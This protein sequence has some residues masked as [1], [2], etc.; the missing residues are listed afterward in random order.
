MQIKNHR[1]WLLSVAVMTS[2]AITAAHPG[3]A[4]AQ[5]PGNSAAADPLT[6]S[7]ALKRA[8]GASPELG[9]ARLER[10]AAQGAVM[11]G[12]ARPNP[13]A[14]Y[15]VE[16]TRQATRTTTLQLSQPIELGGKRAARIN[17]AE[18]GRDIAA[19]ELAAREA[20][21]RA[22]VTGH[23]FGVVA[24]QEGV[25]LAQDSVELARHASDAAAKRVQA[26]KV[27]PVEETRSRVA[28]ANARLELSKAQSELG[29]AR[30]R[31]AA[32][33]GDPEPRFSQAQGSVDDLP[34][35]ISLDALQARLASSPNLQRAQ[36]EIERR[37]ALVDLERARR[38][39]DVTVSLGIKR[40]EQFGRNQAL[41]GVSF[42]IPVFDSNRGN[43][44]EALKRQD[45]AQDE[46]AALQNR[47]NSEAFEAR[48]RL[49]SARE[50]A[51]TLSRDVLPGA[52]SA[53][54]AAGK[55]FQLGKFNFLDVLDAQ[56]TLFQA[57]SQY[58]R[59]LADAHRAVADVERLL[60]QPAETAPPPDA[61]P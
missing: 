51:Q 52:Q 49:R 40:D 35:L 14:S 38:M 54:E 24:A 21:V 19:A 45:K 61:R 55:G 32:S 41:I 42:P 2:L 1:S 9:V 22:D 33:W 53:Y 29:V 37:Q 11:Q 28:Q 7:V 23:F 15:A 50:Q 8:F 6:L 59:A 10:E 26:G 5:T 36:F 46:H 17:A 34:E 58:L 39:P 56:R 60:G 43:L 4:V 48:E 44:V 20:E 47:L 30:Q 57:R 13:V 27:S 18:R 25:R 31:L 3:Q 12:Q 16:D